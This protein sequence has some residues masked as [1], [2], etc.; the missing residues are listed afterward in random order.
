MIPIL[1]TEKAKHTDV[2]AKKTCVDFFE[3]SEAYRCKIKIPI[4]DD[5]IFKWYLLI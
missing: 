3:K 1:K 4:S 5:D 2:K